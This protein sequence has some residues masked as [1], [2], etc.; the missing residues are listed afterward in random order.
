M[1]GARIILYGEFKNVSNAIE[2]MQKINEYLESMEEENKMNIAL[3]AFGD[4]ELF[5][6]KTAELKKFLFEDT[7]FEKISEKIAEN[8][9]K[10]KKRKKIEVE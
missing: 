5:W 9:T 7:P 1:I 6:K 10:E 8:L 4:E 2:S 3:A